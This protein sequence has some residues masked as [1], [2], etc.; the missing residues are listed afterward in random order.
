MMLK[1]PEIF[2]LI[3]TM[4]AHFRNNISNRFTRRALSAMVLDATAWNLVEE[5]TEKAENYRYQGY[6]LDELYLQILA[7]AKFI[8][9]ARREVAPNLRAYIS[10]GG[11]PNNPADK[12]FRE[13]AVNNF[14]SNLKVLADQL[15][16]IYVKVVAFDKEGA[17]IKP[18]V[19][20]S[21]PELREIG[22]YLIE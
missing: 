5:I 17:G 2:S 12:T 13:M 16:E 20:S 18:P 19:Y 14:G 22:R 4:G 15:N 10:S 6:H 3:E 9:Q 1:S 21:M 8:Y 11:E 7:L